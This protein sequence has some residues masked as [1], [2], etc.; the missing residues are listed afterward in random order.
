MRNCYLVEY[1]LFEYRKSLNLQQKLRAIKENNR[2]FADFLLV[3]QHNPVFTIGK[4]GTR[5]D[6]LAPE[7]I[8]QNEGIDVIEVKRGGEVT[9]HG[10]GQLVGYFHLNLSRAKTSVDQFIWKM[11]EILIRILKKYKIEGWRMEGYPGVWVD[12]QRRK[13]KMAAIGA[14]V[15]KMITSHG[16]ALNINTNMDHFRMIVPCGITEYEPIS[17]KQVLNESLV[18]KEIYEIFEKVFEEVFEMKLEKISINKF[19]EMIKENAQS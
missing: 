2:D 16:L 17:M 3:L 14:R 18:I 9:Y 7:K 1:N 10:P 15:S 13:W 4:R 11:E 5:D 6:I 19:E 8:L 12:Y